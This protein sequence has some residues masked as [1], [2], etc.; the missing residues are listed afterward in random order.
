[1]AEKPKDS[2]YQI[3]HDRPN[4]IGCGACTAVCPKFWE[5]GVDGKSR[6]KGGKERDDSWDEKDMDEADL[7]S[8]KEAADACPVNVIHIIEKSTG[9]KL[10]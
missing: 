3:Q 1:M 2:P 10:I 9:K 6:I 8:N 4:C 7:A 5:M